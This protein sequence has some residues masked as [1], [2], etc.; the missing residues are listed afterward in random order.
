M[1]TFNPYDRFSEEELKIV[2]SKHNRLQQLIQ[3]SDKS[4]YLFFQKLH[5][6]NCNADAEK[7]VNNHYLNSYCYNLYIL[8]TLYDYIDKSTQHTNL[9]YKD[10]VARVSEFKN[11]S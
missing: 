1:K 3:S 9:W 2:K 8:V 11:S 10:L 7:F 5:L 6:T 4:Q